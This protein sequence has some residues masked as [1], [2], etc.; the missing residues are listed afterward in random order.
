MSND[1]LPCLAVSLAMVAG[2]QAGSPASDAVL[3]DKTPL[4]GFDS[5][6][7]AGSPSSRM[8]LVDA[9]VGQQLEIAIDRKLVRRGSLELVVPDVEHFM[10][11]IDSLA[12]SFTGFVADARV[13]QD[14]DGHHRASVALRVPEAHFTVVLDALKDR[15]TVRA[16]AVSSEDVTKAYFDLETRLAVTRETEARLRELL[17]SNTGKLSEVL[18]VERELSRVIG[19]IESMEGEKRYF[20]SQIALATIDLTLYEPAAIV[21][22]S[23]LDPLRRAVINALGIFVAS[24]AALVQVIVVALPWASMAVVGWIVARRV[25]IRQAARD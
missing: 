21:R 2:C 24:L 15:G 9:T 23:A 7:D 14:S 25:R 6:T 3:R 19:Q 4:E 12:T 17:V 8:A 11:V 20:D 18:Q 10:G 16:H 1:I 22:A 13:Q 5:P